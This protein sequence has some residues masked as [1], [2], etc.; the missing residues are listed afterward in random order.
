MKRVSAITVSLLLIVSLF[1]EAAAFE[2]KNQ[3]IPAPVITAFTKKQSDRGM[4]YTLSFTDNTA[5]AEQLRKLVYDIALSKHGSLDRLLQSNEAYLCY[6][7]KNFCQISTDKAVWHTL[8]SFE[9]TFSFTLY[10]DILP[11]L[12]ENGVELSQL[13]DGFTLYV[14]MLTASDNFR[15]ENTETVYTY[16]FS[17]SKKTECPSFCHIDVSLPED[18]FF[19]ET[20]ELGGFFS[21]PLSEDIRLPSPSRQGY[22]FDGW[23]FDGGKRINTIPKGTSYCSLFSHWIPMVYEINYYLTTYDTDKSYSFGAADN[24][25]NPVSYTV[26]EGCKLY[27]ILPPVAGFVFDGWYYSKDLS[28]EKIT[29][30]GPSETGDKIL[31]AKWLSLKDIEEAKEKERLEYIKSKKF[32]DID[33]NGFV[34]A[35]DARLVLRYTVGLEKIDASVIKRAD[36]RNSGTISAESARTTLRIAVGLDSLY[37]ILLENGLL[38]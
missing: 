16:T 6:D 34:T 19:S 26:G 11:L 28:G 5:E 22:T 15:E 9:N 3:I 2:I 32:G 30:I 25:K 29:E 31:Y 18:A 27:D 21:E 20:F 8:G 23:S 10:D 35:A 38:P 24:S 13:T 33:D 36:Y 4:E 37:D 17:E 1:I 14:R 12:K 7:T